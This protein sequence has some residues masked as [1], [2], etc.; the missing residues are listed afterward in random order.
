MTLSG[1]GQ[2]TWLVRMTEAAALIGYTHSAL[3]GRLLSRVASCVFCCVPHLIFLLLLPSNQ[4]LEV[5]AV[6]TAA[7]QLGRW[8]AVGVFCAGQV[9]VPANG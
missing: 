4:A 1:A 5:T 8:A 2:R 9:A 6:V 7:P 3:V